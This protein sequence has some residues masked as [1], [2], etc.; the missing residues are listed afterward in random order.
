M[1]MAAFILAQ[2]ERAFARLVPPVLV[3]MSGSALKTPRL[4]T[5]RLI[6]QAEGALA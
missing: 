4:K 1:K 3:E 2:S 5:P 6:S